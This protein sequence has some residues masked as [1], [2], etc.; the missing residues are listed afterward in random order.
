MIVII[1]G[2]L[3]LLA[4]Q[5]QPERSY[6]EDPDAKLAFTVDTLYFDT[7]F[8]TIGTVTKSFRIKNPSDQFIKIDEITLAGGK[9][10]VF[11]INVDGVPGTRFSDLGD[12]APGTVCLFSWRLHW[13]PMKQLIYC[14]YRK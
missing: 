5:C 8:T 10:S 7:V 1:L 4:F 11:R 6:V 3:C 9:S 2:V 12:S 13:I 14:S